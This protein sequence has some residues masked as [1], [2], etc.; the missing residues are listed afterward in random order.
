MGLVNIFPAA[1]QIVE[2]DYLSMIFA[3]ILVASLIVGLA[4]GLLMSLVEFCAGFGSIILAAVFCSAVSGMLMDSGLGTGVYDGIHDGLLSIGGIDTTWL[5]TPINELS[6]EIINEVVVSLNIPEFLQEPVYEAIADMIKVETTDTL[7]QIIASTVTEYVV[8]AIAFIS[9]WIVLAIVF[10][11]LK[12]LAKGLNKVAILGTV[13]RLLGAVFGL[14]Q[15]IVTC[16]IV[17]F[18]IS[19]FAS[20]GMDFAETIT[21]E[22]M[23]ISDPEVYTISKAFYELNLVQLIINLFI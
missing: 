13:N 7:A 3:V 12:P 10:A 19:I 21:N 2:F 1:D 5:S 4:K 9:L 18:I 15:G 17:C 14:A 20:T 23:M 22:W 8:D 16:S 6:E 11:L